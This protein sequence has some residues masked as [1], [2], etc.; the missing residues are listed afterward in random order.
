[1]S[2]FNL[3]DKETQQQVAQSEVA[4]ISSYII[5]SAISILFCGLLG[6]IATVYSIL[7][8]QAKKN[9]DYEKA[10]R[11]SGSAKGWMIA[12]YILGIV[13]T[14]LAWYGRGGKF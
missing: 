12:A 4:G 14:F 3:D 8:L 1:M 9:L 2:T 13:G 5:P 7:T 10:W 6:I 11:Y